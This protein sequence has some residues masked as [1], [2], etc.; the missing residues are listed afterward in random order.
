[1]KFYEIKL[2]GKFGRPQTFEKQWKAKKAMETRG[3]KCL[4]A[5]VWFQPRQ[6]PYVV[7]KFASN[8]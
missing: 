4:K 3:E 1:M 2:E 6:R 5:C 8:R 7:I